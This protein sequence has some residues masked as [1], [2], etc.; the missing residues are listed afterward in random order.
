M[1]R[2]FFIWTLIVFAFLTPSLCAEERPRERRERF[3]GMLDINGDGT[4]TLDE[5][6]RHSTG[7]D[8]IIG[9]KGNSLQLTLNTLYHVSRPVENL[10]YS[11]YKDFINYRDETGEKVSGKYASTVRVAIPYCLGDS[12]RNFRVVGTTGDLF[13]KV[14]Y[15]RQNDGTPQNYTF[16]QG[17][18]FRED[19]F[20]GAVIGSVAAKQ[21]G[22]KIGDRFPLTHGIVPDGHVHD[23]DAFHVTGIL[24]PTG[25]LNDRAV[26]VNMEGFYL[27]ESHA[28]PV[29][30]DADKKESKSLPEAQREV[31]AIL[32]FLKN[33]IHA[34]VIQQKV[35]EG[36]IAQAVFPVR[37]IHRVF[38][39]RDDLSLFHELSAA[40]R[41]S[42]GKVSQNHF[43]NQ[44]EKNERR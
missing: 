25:R 38:S 11:F 12:Y 17:K 9:A 3:F 33:P 31:T 35:R 43:S 6:T 27:L 30:T 1:T 15:G 21:A 32:L 34:M 2:C 37:E 18:N 24:N 8:L 29:P 19:D 10:P 40:I 16:A 13:E 28:K 5:I 41:A 36:N 39:D 4:L 26:F 22:L 14:P 7:P 44:T 42:G 23:E 20:F